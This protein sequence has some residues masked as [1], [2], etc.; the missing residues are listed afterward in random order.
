MQRE[1]HLYRKSGVRLVYQMTN[2]VDTSVMEHE[3]PF[4]ALST[5][6]MYPN[7]V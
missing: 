7:N 2:L 5:Y 4:L 1:G 3:P 6:G